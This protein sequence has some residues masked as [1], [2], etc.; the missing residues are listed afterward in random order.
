MPPERHES[1]LRA[2]GWDD[3]GRPWRSANSIAWVAS[4]PPPAGVP[5]GLRRPR[6]TLPRPGSEARSLCAPAA[7]YDETAY[8]PSK[9]II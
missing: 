5:L 2:D 6:T 3:A 8:A 7:A 1:C 4:Q 9:T